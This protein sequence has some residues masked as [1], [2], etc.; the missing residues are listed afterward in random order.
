MARRRRRER[1]RAA[2]A[3]MPPV[4]PAGA[5]GGQ[6]KPLAEADIISLFDINFAEHP[7]HNRN[8]SLLG[9]ENQ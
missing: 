6:Y 1:P 2:D 5:V 8:L 7:L 3:P 9:A 4:A